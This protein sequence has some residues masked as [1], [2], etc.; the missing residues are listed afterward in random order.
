M[1]YV[2]RF[3][4]GVSDGG[5]GDKNL[6]GGKG[7]N[8]AEMASIGLPVP[9]GFTIST[10]MCTR[11]YEEGEQFPQE[12]RDEVAAGIAHIEAV[13]EKRFG[14]PANPLLVSV[15]S[16]ARVS[17]P[18]MM[19]TVLNL[20]LNDD[21]VEGLAKAAD[22]ERFAWDSYRR[23]IQMYAD[24]V[25]ELDHGAFE[26]ALEIAKED[27]GFTL[28]TEMSAA[29]WKALVA[30]YKALVEE[31]WGKP[32]PQDVHDQLW[33]AVGAVFGSWQSERAKVYRRLND[34]P[35]NWGTAVNVQAM[36]F[37]NMGDTSATGVAFTRDPSKGDRAYYGEF[38]INAQGEDVVAGIRTPQYLTKAAR[39][40]AGAKPA[41]MEEAMPE[42]YRELA[43]VFDQ[44]ETHYRDM[45]DIEFT[46]EQA[47][48]WM[49]QTRSG[50]RT[51][52]A[53][54][55]IAVDMA[56]EGLITREEAIARVDPAALDQLLHP[57]LDPEAKRDVL[58]KGLPASPGAASGKVVFDADTAEK[59]AA[60]GES[61]ILVRVETS[62]EDIHG[63][64]AAKGI[65]TARGGMTSHAAVVARGM[66]RPCVSGA[67]SL[68]ISAKDKVLRCAGREVREGDTL[69]IDG[70][71]GEVMVGEVATV[72][73]ELAGDFGTL[74]EWA[75]AVRRLKVRANAETPLDCKTAREFG[76]EGVGLCRTEHMFFEADRITAV[77]QMILASDEQGR[78]VALDR[79]LPEQRSDFTAIFEV[80]AGLPVTV[81]LLD[82]PLH[83]F[84]PHEE[85]EFAEVA[86]AAGLDIDTLKRRANELHEFNPM[87]GHRGCRLGVTYPEI[88]EMQARAI[89]EAAIDV[90][91]KSGEAPIPEVMIPLVA[92]RRELELM[93]AVVDK[94][95]K[96][97]FAERG[98]EVDYLVGTMI[99]LPRAALKAGEIA[100]VGEFFSF[101]TND[102][103]QTT[104]G[105]S[106]DDAARFLSTY[107]E[108][109]IY[110]KDPFVSLD[111]EGVGE[112][113]SLAAER[114]R[115]TRGDIKLGICGEHGGDP[116]SIAFCEQVGLD[117]VSASPY[118]VPIAR[119]AAA[120]AALQK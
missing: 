89:F 55:K 62:P 14:D 72:Q 6:L 58:T 82:P 91:E 100:E 17:M 34:I 116:A 53:A 99:E 94:A 103:T 97:V 9:P 16:G 35:A 7:A 21:T 57:T 81:R 2:Y 105:V 5:K 107:V 18:G 98:R 64:H 30:Q 93:K 95:A 87:L 70:A 31:Q 47:K 101:G 39:E 79:L 4:G 59:R 84:L 68:A 120:Q 23:F 27:N 52:K 63:M 109:G 75:D 1:T 20:G 28:D 113:V 117:Y 22:D 115:A 51:A 110:A 37:G 44:L 15:R 104:L 45:Q 118:R 10:E 96:L 111:V 77:R 41:S 74:M 38:L 65:L 50:K 67:G 13:T 32:F 78:R 25:L 33:G 43:A 119:L 3:G 46:V 66:G 40:E 54:L 48:L 114:G 56:N 112:L 73:P 69:T 88:Y 90:A 26:E 11:Y 8:L 19:D 36:V 12:L 49:L 108:Q 76:A 86:Q 71:S 42:V 106:R 29:D 80:M 85:A 61:V 60:A 83:E 24:V 92:T 102:L